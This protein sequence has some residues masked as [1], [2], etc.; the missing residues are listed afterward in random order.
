MKHADRMVKE[1]KETGM[2]RPVVSYGH[3]RWTT[4][5]DHTSEVLEVIG[6][7]NVEIGNDAPRGG[8]TGKFIKLKK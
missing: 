6:R 3:G 5:V 2:C 1:L 7:E 8:A 4:Y